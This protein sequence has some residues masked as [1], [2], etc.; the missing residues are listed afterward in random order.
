MF[1]KK[2]TKIIEI[3]P[4]LNNSFEQNISRR[5]KDIA[6]IF[7]LEFQTIKADSVDVVKHSELSTKYIHSK[8]LKNSNYYKNMI[9]KISEVENKLN[10]L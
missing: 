8:I 10:S 2:G 3:A 9:L 4:I 5:Y 1:C 7:N 6:D